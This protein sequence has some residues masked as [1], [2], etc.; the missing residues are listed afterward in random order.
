[1]SESIDSFY[2]QEVTKEVYKKKKGRRRR[3]SKVKKVHESGD[4]S[5]YD[6]D[7]DSENNDSEMEMDFDDEPQIVLVEE[8]GVGIT[9]RDD[10]GQESSRMTW[11]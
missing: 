2:D 5:L 9:S 7:L 10:V 4:E 1:L 8:K 11:I 3:R 6:I